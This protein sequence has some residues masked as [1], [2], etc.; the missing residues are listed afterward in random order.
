MTEDNASANKTYIVL[1]R[2][3]DPAPAAPEER[4]A[5]IRRRAAAQLNLQPEDFAQDAAPALIG[6]V[7]VGNL[8]GGIE[9]QNVYQV[10]V[11]IAAAYR[12]QREYHPGMLYAGEEHQQQRRSMGALPPRGKDVPPPG[13]RPPGKPIC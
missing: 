7:S 2:D 13:G 10:P 11:T 8:R 12:L 4:A 9:Q 1:F 5:H 3:A 6:T